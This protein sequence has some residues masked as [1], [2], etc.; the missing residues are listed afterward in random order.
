MN[1]HAGMSEELEGGEGGCVGFSSRHTQVPIKQGLGFSHVLKVR[2]RIAA[3][4]MR[5]DAPT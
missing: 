5:L 3:R 4:A 2:D 1:V